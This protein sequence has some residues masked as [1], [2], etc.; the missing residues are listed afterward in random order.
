MGNMNCAGPEYNA[1]AN[2]VQAVERTK[3]IDEEIG[4]E[5]RKKGKE[6]KLVLLGAGESGKSTIAKQ[7]KIIHLKG[8]TLEERNALRMLVYRN[9]FEAM[10]IL[11]ASSLRYKYEVAQEN[12]VWMRDAIRKTI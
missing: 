2:D 8:Y 1:A 4:R 3:I 5:K 9:I 6:V 11:I 7:M 10:K 12:Q